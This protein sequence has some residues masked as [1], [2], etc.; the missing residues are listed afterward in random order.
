MAQKYRHN[1]AATYGSLAYD[2]DA[3]VRERQLEEAGTMP[4]RRVERKA[5]PVQRRRS[6]TRAQAKHAP[7]PL[8][9]VESSPCAHW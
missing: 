9:W 8:W 2:L 3:L 6:E 7:P 5:E 1:G 4:E